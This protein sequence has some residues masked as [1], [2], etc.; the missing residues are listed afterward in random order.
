MSELA[1]Q[2]R[3]R[4]DD[5]EMCIPRFHVM[6]QGGKWR[7]VR[8]GELFRGPYPTRDEAVCAARLLA[9][10]LEP[11]EVLVH[12]STGGVEAEILYGR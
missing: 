11:S 8:S 4:P 10:L 2:S 6:P 3:V 9:L 12:D 7:V 1:A 5:G